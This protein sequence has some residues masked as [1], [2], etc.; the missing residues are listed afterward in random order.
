MTI[1]S[2]KTLISADIENLTA[3]EQK[4]YKKFCGFIER[5]LNSRGG[6]GGLP[7]KLSYRPSVQPLD[8]TA[9]AKQ[10][11]QEMRE[12]DCAINVNMATSDDAAVLSEIA[13]LKAVVFI[14]LEI[15]VAL[16]R[17]VFCNE[18]SNT[19]I[20]TRLQ[21][22]CEISQPT[23]ILRILNPHS[24]P[25]DE[26]K[27]NQYLNLGVP[28]ET[29]TLDLDKD[30]Y[31]TYSEDELTGLIKQ[32]AIRRSD[33]V[34]LNVFGPTTQKLAKILTKEGYGN[35]LSLNLLT[36]NVDRLVNLVQCGEEAFPNFSFF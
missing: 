6:I 8:R 16:P 29:I 7:V 20:F 25:S 31:G 14:D 11:I 9:R 1:S 3:K 17:N 21:K 22:Y 12:T 5:D 30:F 36:W 32:T 13:T 15:D 34:V 4:V 26:A 28:V 10:Q 33:L 2:I 19:S 24:T 23:K 27:E 18:Q 35:L